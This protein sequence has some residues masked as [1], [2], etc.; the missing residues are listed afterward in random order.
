MLSPRNRPLFQD[1]AAARPELALGAPKLGIAG[2][3]GWGKP[4]LDMR[5]DYAKLNGREMAYTYPRLDRTWSLVAEGSAP[6]APRG[7]GWHF[8]A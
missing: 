6:I 4:L 8:F 5:A 3:K 7:G 2:A 1:Q